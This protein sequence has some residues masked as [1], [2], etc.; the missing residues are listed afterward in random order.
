ML[1]SK[2]GKIDA[3]QV[4]TQTKFI[5]S[6]AQYAPV[7]RART[8]YAHAYT[9]PG[10]TSLSLRAIPHGAPARWSSKQPC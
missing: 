9:Q 8:A 2:C 4:D 3:Q 1:R 7:W 10:V 5:M 6:A